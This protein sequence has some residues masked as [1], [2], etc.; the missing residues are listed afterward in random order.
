MTRASLRRLV[1]P[2]SG[3]LVLELILLG[4]GTW[5]VHRLHWKEAILEDIAR[6]EAAP[7]VPLAGK[8]GP[9]TKVSVSGR[10]RHDLA[11][12]YGADVRDTATGPQLG[13]YLIVPLER[14]NEPTLLVDRGWVPDK[15]SGPINEP[16]GMVS[17]SGYIHPADHPGMFSARDDPAT[18]TFY[19]LDPVAIGAALGLKNVAPFVLIA[20]G[21][22]PAEH[23]PE[24]ATHL[25]RPPND[26]FIYAVT[27]YGLALA[28]VVMFVV[29]ARGMLLA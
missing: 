16:Q 3:L 15:R 17:I 26:H 2:L 18:R 23:Y 20:L 14:S 25:P 8:P 28:L 4:L 1:W 11:A 21:P 10:L 19:T 29:W 12:S 24:P 7:A 13:S 6:A 9:F 22:P 27:W 5:Q